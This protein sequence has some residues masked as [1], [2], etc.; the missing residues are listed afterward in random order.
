MLQLLVII[1]LVSTGKGIYNEACSSIV[2]KNENNII[3]LVITACF[4]G[5]VRLNNQAST[6]ISGSQG[7]VELC[8]DQI[9]R[10]V[11]FTTISHHEANIICRQ[12]GYSNYGKLIYSVHYDTTQ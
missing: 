1:S 3:I 2:C 4:N 12:Q 7:V 10:P 5:E 6:S 8:H 9:W 11:C